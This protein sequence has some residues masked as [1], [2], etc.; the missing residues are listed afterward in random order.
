M[1][2]RL[3]VGTVAPWEIA[4]AIGLLLAAILVALV[5]AARIYA[6][7]VLLYGQRPSVGGVVRAARGR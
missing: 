1:V 6:A 7:G 4:L 5:V 2:A 3:V